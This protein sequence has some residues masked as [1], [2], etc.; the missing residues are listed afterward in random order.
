MRLQGRICSLEVSCE[1]NLPEK[2]QMRK[3]ALVVYDFEVL[4]NFKL[5]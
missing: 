4:K 2:N 3:I 5:Q 1:F